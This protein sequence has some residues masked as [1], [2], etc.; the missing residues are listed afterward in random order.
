MCLVFVFFEGFG[1][2]RE[3]HVLTH[4][5]PTRRS[6]DLPPQISKARSGDVGAHSRTLRDP[7]PRPRSAQDPN[8]SGARSEEHTSELQSLMRISSAV[9]CLKT[10]MRS[11]HHPT[12]TTDSSPL[13]T[14]SSHNHTSQYTSLIL[15][16]YL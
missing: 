3:L 11:Q 10:Q 1:D 13:I 9:F 8:L 7:V 15:Y 12:R 4:S 6:S 5:F 2:H 14:C 16:T